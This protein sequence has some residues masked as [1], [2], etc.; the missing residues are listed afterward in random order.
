VWLPRVG[1]HAAPPLAR[2]RLALEAPAL[3]LWGARSRGRAEKRGIRRRWRQKQ[4]GDVL[5]FT[6]WTLLRLFPPLRAAWSRAGEPALV[7]VTGPNAKRVLCGAVQVHTGPRVVL[8]RKSAGGAEVRAFLSAW[9]RR[10]RQAPT[11]GRLL[12]R[13]PAHTDT[14]TRRLAAELGIVLLWWPKPWPA[15]NAMDHLGKELKRLI[16][17]NRQAASIDE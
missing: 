12:D 15:L 4:P 11:I 16:A 6:D 17:A 13:A 10:Y 5:L 9:R 1:T 14:K 2:R 3:S 8:R 7:P